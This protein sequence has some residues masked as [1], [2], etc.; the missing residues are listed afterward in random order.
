MST[1]GLYTGCPVQ[2]SL[3]YIAGKWQIGIL[4][5]L[6]NGSLRFGALKAALP[7]ITEKMLSQELR[8]FEGAGVVERTVFAS[9]P[10]RVEYR[11]TDKGASLL[12][13]LTAI[14][15]WGY[16]HLQDEKLSPGMYPTP[17]HT[18]EE[19]ESRL[20]AKTG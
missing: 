8:F 2:Y 18:M 16:A 9:V 5:N 1:P 17:L 12:P 10:P 11:L 6:R 3:K 14:V 20:S 4:W 7:G 19:I 13:V 15:E